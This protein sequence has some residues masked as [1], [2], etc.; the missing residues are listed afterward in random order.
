MFEELKLVVSVQNTDPDPAH[1]KEQHHEVVLEG[2]NTLS[3]NYSQ[4]EGQELQKQG[5][6]SQIVSENSSSITFMNK[7]LFQPS[8]QYKFDEI[9]GPK[10]EGVTL[11]EKLMSQDP[12]EVGLNTFITVSKFK[13]RILEITSA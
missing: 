8:K 3:L 11:H 7:Q 6:T 10:H 13:P 4:F 9:V 12:D 2:I 1:P 5:S